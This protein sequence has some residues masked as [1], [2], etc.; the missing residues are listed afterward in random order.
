MLSETINMSIETFTLYRE[1]LPCL[2]SMFPCIRGLI[3]YE[4]M[5]IGTINM[6]NETCN[7]HMNMFSISRRT[8]NMSRE[9]C[10]ISW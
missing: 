1:N 7:M 10:T 5:C 9:K 3:S 4:I 6:S 8:I 2:G